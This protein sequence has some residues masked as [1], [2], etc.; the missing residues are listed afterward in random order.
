[1]LFALFYIDLSGSMCFCKIR[2]KILLFFFAPALYL[3][4]MYAPSRNRHFLCQHIKF[5][6]SLGF[7][8]LCFV[9]REE[10]REIDMILQNV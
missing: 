7:W 5:F 6:L 1:M 2:K 8:V 4:D 9:L 10:R 3:C